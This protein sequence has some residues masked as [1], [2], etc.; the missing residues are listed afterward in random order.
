MIDENM[1]HSHW[2][3]LEFVT[4]NIKRSSILFQ[5]TIVK[6]CTGMHAYHVL[7]RN[8]ERE[9]TYTTHISCFGWRLLKKLNKM[10]LSL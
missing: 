9:N 5:W 8:N 7:K 3:I 2:N 1:R 6:M 10:H 4:V